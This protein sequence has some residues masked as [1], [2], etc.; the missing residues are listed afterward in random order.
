MRRH[1]TS[2]IGVAGV[3]RWKTG[4]VPFELTTFVGRRQA[5]AEVRHLLSKARLVTLT[6][7]GGVGKSRLAIHVAQQVRRAF[8]DG[9][10]FV[11]LAKVQD[12]SLTANAVGAALELPDTV[13]TR[14]PA[15]ALADY[16]ADQRLLLVLDNCEHLSQACALLV[17]R[18]L[19]AV[20]GLQVLATSREPLSLPAEHVWPVQPLTMPG[21][22]EVS[23]VEGAAGCAYEA[24]ALFE[25]RAS[26]V[27]PGFALNGKNMAAVARLCQRLDGLPLAIELAAVWLRTLSVEEILTRL[28]DRFRLLTKGDRVGLPRHQ[29]LQATVEWSFDLCT[30]LERIIWARLSVFAGG[31]DLEAAEKVCGGDGLAVDDVFPGLAGLVDKSVL[32]REESGGRARYRILE[33]IRQYGS[34]RL[35]ESAEEVTVRRRHRDYYLR[36]AEEAETDWFGPNQ[37]A[38]LDRFRIDQANVWAALEFC[39]TESGG[40]HAVGGD[41]AGLRMVGALWW[42]WIGRAVRDGRNWLDRALALDTEPSR[43]RAKALWV[44]GWIATGQGDVSHSSSMLDECCVLSRQ[45]GDTAA[46]AYATQWIGTTKWMQ[47]LL[48]ESAR[49]LERA[50]DSHRASGEL[51]SVTAVVPCQL[52]MVAGLLGDDRLA[53]RLCEECV[54]LCEAYGECW[55]RS[56]ALWNLAVTRWS[57]DDL[58]QAN[59]RA[60][61]SLRVKRTINDQLGIPFCMEF[62]AWI[63]M[64]DGDAKRAALLLGVSEKMWEPIGAPL[65]GWGTLHGWSDHCRVRA[66]EVLGKEAFEAACQRGRQFAFDAAVAF[67]LDERPSAPSEAPTTGPSAQQLTRREREVAE[68]VADGR[69]NKEIAT[70]LVISQRTAEGHVEHILH[71]LGFASRTQIVAWVVGQHNGAAQ[72]P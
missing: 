64:A 35:T 18:L 29:T 39:L 33:T 61:E 46:L 32:A 43:E 62:L 36:L 16:L 19:S 63:A 20:P 59:A 60:R 44:T 42:Y 71:K 28:E 56:W 45:L 52:G 6:G 41:H 50:A 8:P 40:G 5:T 1:W 30:D 37:A 4:E 7:V 12:P 38:W 55:T 67:A 27:V 53:T 70:S 14:D 11:E 26:S 22:E 31:L 9:V 10:R 25:D 49:L 47:D 17:S 13:S 48:P 54:A 24:L 23:T 2:V 15:E 66:R 69:S 68:L 58:R 3:T 21:E 34:E 57:Q 65:F 51:N 72:P